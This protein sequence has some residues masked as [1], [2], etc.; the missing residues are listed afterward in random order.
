MENFFRI[1]NVKFFFHWGGMAKFKRIQKHFLVY[2]TTKCVEDQKVK[3]LVLNY[4]FALACMVGGHNPRFY[5]N[6]INFIKNSLHTSI[7]L[8]TVQC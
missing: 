5:I 6:L 4:V 7:L 1:F 3:K 2:I 8:T